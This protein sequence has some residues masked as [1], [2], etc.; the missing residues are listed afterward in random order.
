VLA[1][2]RVRVAGHRWLAA[3][4]HRDGVPLAAPA[5]ARARRLIGKR[6]A[7]LVTLQ[8]GIPFRETLVPLVRH[9]PPDWLWLVRPHRQSRVA[10]AELE[11]ELRGATGR[12]I[13]VRRAAGLPLYAALR[14]CAGHVTGFSTCALEALAFGVPT[15][16]THE[17]GLHAYA[18][19]VAQGVMWQHRSPQQSAG[20]L[21]DVADRLGDACRDAAR[22]LF[23]PPA[24]A[25]GLLS[26]AAG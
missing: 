8:K 2:D 25:L 22:S 19:L 23:A 24:D 18:D 16:L 1:P 11:S 14:A 20:R 13:E 4:T 26:Q 3:W 9:A 12:S 17:S 15:L 21:A 10:P 7:L 5:L 6:R